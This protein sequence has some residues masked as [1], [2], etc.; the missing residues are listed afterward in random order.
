MLK[1]E[2]DTI[3]VELKED[4]AELTRIFDK[5]SE[6]E[7]L[8]HADGA[9][10]ARHS[11][12]LF[13]TVGRLVEDTY[14]VDGKPFHLGQHG[15][16]RDRVFH[17]TEQGEK[18]ITLRLESDADSLAIYPFRF[19]L[20]IAYRIEGGTIHVGYHVM[21]LDDKTMHFSIGAH[22]A[23]NV[24]FVPGEVFEDYYLEF[25]AE[26]VLDSLTLSG[27]YLSGE[28]KKIADAKKLP[29]NYELFGN[30]ALIFEGLTKNE[31]TIRS[32]K[33]RHFVKVAFPDFKYVGIW[34]PK[35][36]TPFLCIE[37]WFGIA[38]AKGESVEL[39]DKLG[40]ETLAVG[41][42]FSSEYTITI[43]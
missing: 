36:G 24:P 15:F 14:L 6:K 16:A 35:P 42:D 8:W 34:T 21:N 19:A 20:E 13:P 40:I 4:G 43:G 25:A 17:V 27:P 10:W 26:E 28:K 29:L 7:F 41:A 30:D 9:F 18:S 2:N 32:R 33:N 38:D 12:V 11:P 39:K 3:L 5:N 22:P 23:F 1:L 31:V 37:P